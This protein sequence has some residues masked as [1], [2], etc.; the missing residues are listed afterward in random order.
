MALVT[1]C[2][3]GVGAEDVRDGG[4]EPGA[5]VGQ[6]ITVTGMVIQ[7]REGPVFRLSGDEFGDAGLPVVWTGGPAPPAGTIAQ[8]SGIVTGADVDAIRERIGGGLSEE[9]LTGVTEPVVLTADDVRPLVPAAAGAGRPAEETVTDVTARLREGGFDTLLSGLSLA[10]LD[11]AV[12]GETPYTLFAPDDQAFTGGSSRELRALLHDPEGIDELLH[13]HVV[14]GAYSLEDLRGR[15]ELTAVGGGTLD[16][17][18]DGDR[19]LVD[20]VPATGPSFRSGRVVV[21]AIGGLLD[22]RAR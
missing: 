6:E 16:V 3:T 17:T 19:A 15:D 10:G 18:T 12:L 4:F 14:E 7:P 1:A 5:L 8:V 21:H 9:D 13:H 22:P 20:G 11:G 2:T